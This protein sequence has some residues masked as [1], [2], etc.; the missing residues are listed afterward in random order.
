MNI[1]PKLTVAL[2]LMV[3][4]IMATSC[5]DDIET[6][7]NTDPTGNAISF[8][9]AVGHSTRATETTISNLGDFAVFA[10]GMHQN[11]VLYDNFL[12]GTPTETG[13]NPEIAHRLSLDDATTGTWKLSRDVYWPSALEKVLFFAYTALQNKDGEVTSSSDVLKDTKASFGFSKDT[14]EIAGFKPLKDDVTEDTNKDGTSKTIWADGRNQRDLLVAFTEQS[15]SV[16]ATNVSI[17][18]THAL[19][20]I[21]ITAKQKGLNDDNRVD[22]RIVKIKGAWIVNA[23]EGGDLIAAYSQEGKTGSVN[24]SW[25]TAGYNKTATYGSFYTNIVYLNDSEDK[26]LLGGESLMLIPENL[27]EWNAKGG[28]ENNNGAYILLLCRIELQHKGSN[29]EG[30]ADLD[31][32]AIDGNNHYHQLFPVNEDKYNGAQY[33]FACVP[34]SS[35]WSTDGIGKHYTYSLNI[36]GNGTGAGKYPPMSEADLKK[37][38]PSGTMVAVVGKD[39]PQ[40]PLEV[41]TSRPSGKN[42]GDN[43]LDNPIQ[44]T[45]TVGDWD[46]P[47]DW[48][49]GNIDL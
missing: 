11:G 49:P 44:F 29:H 14:P 7:I 16:S 22:N 9:P 31:D 6:G 28:D 45:V 35:T 39:G 19:T 24:N 8:A 5:A 17:N 33:G 26:D 42:V 46:E 4:A 2:S 40:Q 48:T 34:L 38:V 43:V 30:N 15:R 36:C 23:T 1:I 32:I 10:R 13:I 37:L 20:Q 47:K 12:I 27:T 3:G 21:S 18:F 25:S 41:V